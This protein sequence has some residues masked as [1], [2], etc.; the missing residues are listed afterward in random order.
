MQQHVAL[1]KARDQLEIA[2]KQYSQGVISYA[3]TIVYKMNVDYMEAILN[4]GNMQQMAS[5]VNLYQA[6][7]G[8]Y[9]SQPSS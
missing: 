6:L 1:Q 5:L 3:E 4:D 2:R 9:L 7:G 8:G